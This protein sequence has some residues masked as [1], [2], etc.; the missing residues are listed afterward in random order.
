MKPV[1]VN[2]I[3]TGEWQGPCRWDSVRPEVEKANAERSF[4]QWSKQLKTEAGPGRR[5]ARAGTGPRRVLGEPARRGRAVRQ[6]APDSSETDVYYMFPSGNSRSSCEIG[7]KFGKPILLNGLGC[8]NT[9]IA[10]FTLAQGNEGSSR[11]TTW[12]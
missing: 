11:A 6:L 7:N 1:M 2:L 3:H 9:D 12:I 8:R 10:S 4:A 5:R